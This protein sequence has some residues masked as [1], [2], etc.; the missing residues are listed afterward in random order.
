MPISAIAVSEAD[1]F[2]RVSTAEQGEALLVPIEIKNNCGIMGFKFS[3][4]Y[5]KDI[6]ELKSVSRGKI[7]QNGA[8]NDSIGVTESGKVD[9]V[10]SSTENAVGDGTV[11]ILNFI[12]L[13]T[14]ETKISIEYSQPDTFNENYEDVILNCNKVVV[15]SVENI[16]SS[17]ENETQN[18]GVDSTIIPDN[19]SIKNVV[20]IVLRE[21]E[22]DSL[23][24]L[25]EESR[26]AFVNKVNNSVSQITQNGNSYF[27]DFDS[28]EDTYKNTVSQEFVDSVL[29]SVDSYAVDSS[30]NDALSAVGC[31]DIADI[32]DNKKEEF[33]Q[34][35]ED[36][37][38]QYMP[39]VDY[40]SD[41]LDASESAETI[42][43]LQQE[44]EQKATE[45]VP[46]PKPQQQRKTIYII[47]ILI[48]LVLICTVIILILIKSKSKKQGGKDN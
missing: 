11:F 36:N 19:E 2:G 33:V 5:D 46:V 22:V 42:E 29:E 37:L 15:N 17:S 38:K 34:L 3:V 20:E 48:L 24:M 31:D 8:L 30:I 14:E 47:I 4:F 9:I 1:I 40:I 28:L 23:E 7:T 13:Q 25:P 32:P 27:S 43:K 18:A 16:Q 35:V 10:W 12:V 44:N 26:E 21:F 45:G 39:D 6:L 41:T